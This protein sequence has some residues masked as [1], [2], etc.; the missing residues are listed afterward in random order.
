M[1]THIYAPPPFITSIS[2][3]LAILSYMSF[4]GVVIAFDTIFQFKHYIH[5]CTMQAP[6]HPR[7]HTCTCKLADRCNQGINLALLISLVQ[8]FVYIWVWLC[9]TTTTNSLSLFVLFFK[10][11]RYQFDFVWHCCCCCWWWCISC[12][13]SHLS[14]DC[15]YTNRGTNVVAGAISAAASATAA[16]KRRQSK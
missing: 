12:T 3:S 8:C 13:Y 16:N 9:A 6:T 4:N 2:I 1:K 11:F 10:Y 7:T 15:F 5:I 14:H